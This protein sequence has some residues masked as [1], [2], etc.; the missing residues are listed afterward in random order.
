MAIQ[1]GS[2][3]LGAGAV[4]A[5]PVLTRLF[6]PFLVEIVAAGMSAVD[7]TT[8]LVAEQMEALE[9]IAAEARIKREAAMAESLE[10]L[11]GDET[12]GGAEEAGP[13]RVRAR[14]RPAAGGRRTS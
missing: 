9:D 12:G 10:P 11:D 2:F 7:E 3:L 5:L 14:R 13:S 8:R 6:R 4:L 1:M